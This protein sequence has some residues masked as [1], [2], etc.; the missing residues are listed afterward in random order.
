M[1]DLDKCYNF[2]MGLVRL[3]GD[4]IATRF[5]QNKHIKQKSCD[6]DLVTETDQE[7]E[8][9]IIAALAKEFPH[10]KFIGE[11]QTAAGKR[12]EL[13]DSPTW[14]IDPID[15]TMNFVHGYPHSCIAVAFLVNKE[16]EISI[17]Y[18]PML[19][20]LFTARRGQGAY[21]NGKRIHVS[22]QKELSKSLVITEFGLARDQKKTL[23][24]IENFRKIYQHS[25]GIRSLGTAALNLAMVALGAVDVNYEFGIHAWDYSAGD[26]LVR[27][28]GGVVMDPDGGKLDLLARRVLAASSPELA[29][30]Y[31]KLLT[32]YYPE[33]RD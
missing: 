25:Q 6:A 24:T 16:T 17:I 33:P 27:E 28:A 23:N 10:H 20:Q 8:K 12:A 29:Q 1:E 3:G 7:V 5:Q 2:V 9:T 22:G 26:L 14:I 32:Q 30:E 11:E 18:N 13:T 31:V 4:L 21:L 19:K 15:G